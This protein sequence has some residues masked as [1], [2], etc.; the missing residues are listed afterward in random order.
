MAIKIKHNILTEVFISY[1]RNLNFRSYPLRKKLNITLLLFLTILWCNFN[2]AQDW[3]FLGGPQGV[4]INDILFT[5]SGRLICST[6]HGV[7]ISDNFGQT[8]RNKNFTSTLGS[9][10]NLTECRN[11]NIIATTE[12]GVAISRDSAETWSLIYEL[13]SM[14]AYNSVVLESP[15]DSSLYFS[16]GNNFYKSV[17]EGKSWSVIWKGIVIDGFAIDDSGSIY[18]SVRFGRIYR[19]TDS[20]KS[21]EVLGIEYPIQDQI[22]S[23]LFVNHSGGLYFKVSN[24]PYWLV[25]YENNQAT[26]VIPGWTDIGLGLTSDGDLIFKYDFSIAIYNHIS[27]KTSLLSSPNFVKDQVAGKVITYGNIWIARFGYEGL[28]R[29]T[30]AGKSWTDINEGL[31]YK[32]CISIEVTKANKI[33]VGTFGEAFWGGL[34]KSLDDGNTW[35]KIQPVENDPYFIDISTLSNA[36]GSLIA[37]GSYGVYLSNSEGE[38]W[39]AQSGISL[40]YSQYVSNS[41]VIYVGNDYKGIYVS[42]NNG[43]Y[44]QPSNIGVK[45]DYFFGFGESK[46]GRIFAAAWPSGIYYSDNTL[47]WSY[48]DSGPMTNVQAHNFVFKN[49]TVFSGTSGGILLS[50]DNGITWSRI[51]GIYGNITKI[52]IAPNGDL[53]TVVSN[54]GIYISSNDGYKWK[55]LNTN[56]EGRTVYDLKF[57]QFGRVYAATD[58]GIYRNDYY[59]ITPT[60]QYP[61]NGVRDLP[62]KIELGWKKVNFAKSYRIQLSK[63]SLFNQI[64]YDDSTIIDTSKIFPDLESMTTYYWRVKSISEKYNFPFSKVSKFTTFIPTVFVLK[65]NYP[66]PFNPGTTIEFELPFSTRVILKVFNILGQLVKTIADKRFDVGTHKYKWDA[67]GLAS[68][69]YIL[70]MQAGDFVQSKKIMLLK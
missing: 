20:G 12:R 7:Y 19:S 39:K 17:D 50:V 56:L 67:A 1:L 47:N 21:F 31:G 70:Q 2:S 53:V 22:I 60:P 46:T 41:G 14:K 23:N 43:T 54:D 24:Y 9:V 27:R 64:V 30:D 59:M 36:N 3:K 18:L 58:Y 40:A 57:D 6:H 11:G 62:S 15:R 37:A 51:T 38:V 32:I 29:S 25:H 33:F 13:Y 4:Y 52:R 45:H 63:D 34:Y 16:Y 5:K 44:W 42:R 8:W 26:E 10:F 68:G 61:E 65:Q 49:D 35:S 66:N 48:I 69:V 55:L 28:Y